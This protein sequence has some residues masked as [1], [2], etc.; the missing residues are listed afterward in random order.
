MT[1]CFGRDHRK[2]G[3]FNLFTS[4]TYVIGGDLLT[5]MTYVIGHFPAQFRATAY[6]QDFL[7]IALT[8]SLGAIHANQNCS[9]YEASALAETIA[10]IINTSRTLAAPN[11]LTKPCISHPLP[12]LAGRINIYVAGKGSLLDGTY[13]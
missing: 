2:S 1:V 9:V 12:G 6:V 13:A 10:L 11:P 8:S 3:L 7:P 5:S 4:L